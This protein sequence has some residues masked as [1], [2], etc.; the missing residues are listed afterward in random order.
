MPSVPRHLIH[1]IG[2]D[3]PMTVGGFLVGGGVGAAIGIAAGAMTQTTSSFVSP[4]V[5]GSHEAND[6]V[7]R[8]TGQDH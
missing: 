6:L 5:H 1:R 3:G 2:L 7:G 8:T 4:A